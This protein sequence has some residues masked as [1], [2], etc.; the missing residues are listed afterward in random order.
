MGFRTWRKQ[1]LKLMQLNTVPEKIQFK[2]YLVHKPL[3][4]QGPCCTTSNLQVQR[5]SSSKANSR[6]VCSR[7][8]AS[9]RVGEQKQNEV[10]VWGW[11][12]G[13]RLLCWK[14][15]VLVNTLRPDLEDP[16]LG[17]FMFWCSRIQ[18]PIL[19][20]TCPWKP[21]IRWCM[22]C[23]L[24]SCR[25]ATSGHVSQ[26]TPPPLTIDPIAE[27]AGV[28]CSHI[29]SKIS[30][31][32]FLSN[33]NCKDLSERYACIHGDKYNFF[34]E[35]HANTNSN[36]Q[37]DLHSMR[38]HVSPLAMPTFSFRFFFPQFKPRWQRFQKSR[39]DS[40]KPAGKGH[41][42]AWQAAT[43]LCSPGDKIAKLEQCRDGMMLENSWIPWMELPKCQWYPMALLIHT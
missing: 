35:L 20:R 22:V 1:F 8:S 29:A 33:N 19:S 15:G 32:Q 34:R 41:P 25:R 21:L 10:P 2:R 4:F 14:S 11:K 17:N 13:P 6:Q 27:H 18:N 5:H 24:Q 12:L 43:H 30:H 28:L 31:R 16:Q 38:P 40:R 36:V 39:I 9:T 37:L 7:S 42:A 3:I 23:W 26:K